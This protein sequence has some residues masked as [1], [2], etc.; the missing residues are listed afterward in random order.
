MVPTEMSVSMVA[1]PWRRFFHA[2][3][4]NG[5]AAHS[6]TGVACAVGAG[7]AVGLGCGG[8]GGGVADR[9]DLG[10]D[11]LDGDA[12]RNGDGG[13]F[14]GVVHRCV[15]AVELVEPLGD[16]RGARGAGHPADVEGDRGG[17]A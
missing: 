6:T 7:G 17:R 11:L 8:D 10:D 13:L 1:A 9:F 15:D 2:A 16:P 12:V 4:W 3:R 14:G 5:Y